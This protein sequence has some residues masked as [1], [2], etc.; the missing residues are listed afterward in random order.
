MCT[1]CPVLQPFILSSPVLHFPFFLPALPASPSGSHCLGLHSLLDVLQYL[2]FLLQKLK[3][4][5]G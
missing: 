4:Q 1:P 2:F 3:L 5:L